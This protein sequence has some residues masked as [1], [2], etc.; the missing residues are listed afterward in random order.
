MTANSLFQSGY[1]IYWSY[2]NI[3]QTSAAAALKKNGVWGL[4]GIT[5]K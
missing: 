1:R 2:R 3:E 4:A 5:V